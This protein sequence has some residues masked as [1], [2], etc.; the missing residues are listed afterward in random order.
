[1][2]HKITPCLWFENQAEEAAR[3]YSAIFPNSRIGSITRYGKEGYEIHRQPAGTVMTVE[4]DL[5]GQTFTALNGGPV[6]KFNEA[7]SFQVQCET[8]AEVDYYWEKLSEGGDEQAQQCGWLKDKYGVSWQVIPKGLGKLLSGPDS[9]K[10]QRATKAMLQMKKL[11]IEAIQ[12]AYDGPR[13]A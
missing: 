5:E 11:D 6:F 1:M 12:R 7:I 3:F 8:Q 9:E 13:Q 10:S 2:L 4:F